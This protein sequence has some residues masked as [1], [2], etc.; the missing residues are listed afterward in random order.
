MLTTKKVVGAVPLPL[1]LKDVLLVSQSRESNNQPAT[2]EKGGIGHHDL[3]VTDLC[4]NTGV[5]SIPVAMANDK[6]YR[7]RIQATSS[8]ELTPCGR[9]ARHMPCSI[10]Y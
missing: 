3:D 6:K 2:A 8:K 1:I 10:T 5:A 7:A 4:K 9:S